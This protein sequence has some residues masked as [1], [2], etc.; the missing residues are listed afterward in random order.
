MPHVAVVGAGIIGL[1]TAFVLQQRGARVTVVESGRPGSGQSAGQGRIFRHAHA[2]TRL[3]EQVVRSRALWRGWEDELGVELIAREGAVAV[4]DGVPAKAEA[5]AAFPD[6]PVRR[7]TP[8]ELRE[9]LPLLAGYDGPAM[10]DVHGGAIRTRAAVGALSDRL[11]GSLVTDHVLAVRRRDDG[12][13]EIR[14]GT[15]V[16]TVDHVVLCAGRGTAGLARGVGLEL[17]VEL[18]AHVR[19][20]FRVADPDASPSPT[21]QDGSGQF[22]ETGVYASPY[23]DPRLYAVGLSGATPA[24]ADGGVVDPAALASLAERT[25]AYVERA[26]PGLRPEPVDHVHCWVTRLPWG[27]DGVGVW[28]SDGVTAVAGH[29]LFKQ[30]PV[31]G[32]ALAETALSGV[33]PAPWHHTARLGRD[34]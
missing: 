30:A 14:T 19:L 12:S 13:V 28:S 25:V 5:L 33:V 22:G 17:P 18:G 2:D 24:H 29:N 6:A 15:D 10:L 20:T 4:G 3:V 9:W 1:S 11:A 31:L 16:R 8:D 27:D 23:P 7:L 21:F 26:L 34:D 32:E